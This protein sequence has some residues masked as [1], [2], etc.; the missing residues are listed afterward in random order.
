M[1]RECG[2]KF[3]LHDDQLKQL[4]PMYKKGV[5]NTFLSCGRKYGKTELGAYVLWKQALENPGSE[6]FY[7]TPEAVGGR[8]ILWENGRLKNFLGKAGAKY[9][10]SIRNQDMIIRLKNGSFM[11]VVGSD[12]YMIANG[13]SP[14]I[15]VYDEFKGF[16]HRWHT[17]FAPNRIAKDA[18]FVYIG[19]KPRAGNKNMDQYNEVLEY[20]VKHPETWFVAERTTWDN[21]LNHRPQIKEAIEEEIKQLI[22]RGEEDVVQLEYYSKVVPGGKRAVFPMLRSDKHSF[23]HASLMREISRDVKRM[24]W[25]WIADP[26]NTTAFGM[27]FAC[28]NRY[29]NQLYILD[30]IYETDQHNTSTGIIIPKAKAKCWSLYPESSLEDDWTKVSDEA[31]AWFMTEAMQRYGI[32]FSPAEKWKGTKEEGLSI[33]KDQLI[34]R[35]VK[36]SNRCKNLWKEMEQYAK[37]GSGR[38][39]KRNDHLIDCF[40]YLNM[41][42][43]YDFSTI[44]DAVKVVDKMREGRMNRFQDDTFDEDNDWDANMGDGFDLDFTW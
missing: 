39:P 44:A 22:E 26:G 33:I 34:H 36:I 21:P 12:N 15:A 7:I 32:Y 19:T 41:A 30:E 37:D 27:L 4:R 8:K 9:I 11:Q 43:H 1:G 40:R 2:L 20:A 3:R 42:F 25:G 13:L 24:E 31:A 5:K 14:D 6:C 23:D 18:S 10:D 29:T 35:T 16:N 38:I 17:E 28:L